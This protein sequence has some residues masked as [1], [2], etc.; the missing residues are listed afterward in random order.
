MRIA[1]ICFLLFCVHK[2][3]SQQFDTAIFPLLNKEK[4]PFYFGVASGDPQQ[5][6]IVLWTKII[7]ENN[8][9]KQLRWQIATDTFMQ[10]IVKTAEVTTDSNSAFSAAVFVNDLFPGS[11]Y[12]Y[13]FL[14]GE[15]S[16]SIGRTKTAS[17][18]ADS[19]KFA[20]VS[21]NHFETG[22]FNGFRMIA[23][24]NDL[25][26][27]IHL[28]D[29]IYEYARNKKSKKEKVREHIPVS[30]LLSLQDY[31][32]RYAQ[33]RL[34]EDMQE[35]HRL[36]PVVAIWDDHEFA[37]NMYANGAQ[38]HQKNEGDWQA[39]KE[40]ARKVYFEWLPVSTAP[41]LTIIRKLDYGD[42]AT[43]YMLDERTVARSKQVETPYDST[44][45]A[46]DRT[47]IG[48]EQADWLINGIKNSNSRW[49]V[50]GNQVLF[51]EL[52][53]HQLSKKHAKLLDTWDGY[54]IERAT[55]YDSF[56]ANNIKNL[57]FITGDI[58]TSWAFDVVANP[59]D[60][61]KYNRKTGKGV[62]GA[63]FV[64]PSVSS[65]NLDEKAPKVIA[66][67]VSDVLVSKKNNPHLYFNNM[68]D[69]GYM[70]L[71]L[72]REKATATWHYA[73]TIRKKTT[74]EKKTVTYESLYNDN[75]LRKVKR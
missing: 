12:F 19:L 6:S 53:A 45:Y 36:H 23:N 13:R 59:K 27:V 58:H 60:N 24:R 67:L 65:T 75:R 3:L 34:D 5:N 4:A 28:G 57:V 21:C 43:I 11:Y 40:R 64:T 74:E 72:N 68:T 54:P 46:S 61:N 14:Y 16:S 63:E 10:N 7:P 62:I 26:A 42:L 66:K 18:N 44:L 73:I 20:V 32:S 71:K 2:L 15:K 39:R 48:K 47:M 22:Y 29:Y 51:S 50:I 33:Y 30:E 1:V 35:M 8:T 37:N 31:R 49:K 38:N 56:Y 69:H 55:L 17:K 70:L 9:P 25:D 52:D 41:E